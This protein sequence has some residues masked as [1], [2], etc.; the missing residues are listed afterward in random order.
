MKSESASEGN[1][2]TNPRVQGIKTV[3][4]H[5]FSIIKSQAVLTISVIAMII[6]CFFVPIDREYASYFD[7]KTL[8]FLFCML[9]VIGAFKNIHFFEIA[10]RYIVVKLHNTRNAILG[11]VFI[12]Y[13]TSMF[14][15]N[16]MALLTFLPLSFFVL[17]STNKK[18]YMAFLFIMQN[19]AANLGGMITPFGNPQNLY[20]Y[21]YY[22]IPTTEFFQIMLIPFLT[23]TL[24]ILICCICVKEEPLT[25]QEDIVFEFQIGRILLYSMLFISTILI[26]F[27]V[28]PFDIGTVIVICALLILDRKSLIEVNYSLLLTICAFFVFSGNM[29]RIPAVS[30][31]FH[32][33]LP[34]NPL[35]VGAL[36]CQVISNVPSAILLSKF[37]TN[38]A[39]LLV[40]VNIGGCGTLIASLASLITFSEYKK[41]NPREIKSF[42]VKFTVLNLLFL[43]V[44]YIVQV[45]LG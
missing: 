26:V 12:T 32:Q 9:A 16:D 2:N 44:L 43:G 5:L 35:L 1:P 7:M 11:L 17:N 22:N 36:S 41:H 28:I 13:F 3:S 14:L 25:L 40:A 39:S 30:D 23:S 20:L 10:A 19:F 6:T 45:I 24:L 38:Y 29:A 8:A 15:G 31:F 34:S 37:T 42:I 21:S 27:R 4:K 18:S 33:L